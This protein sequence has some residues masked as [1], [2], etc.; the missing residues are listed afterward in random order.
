MSIQ[1]K[2]ASAAE[3]LSPGFPVP[4]FDATT[5][6]DQVCAC[7][8]EALTKAY[9]TDD[10]KKI[11][12][13]ITGGGA[14][15]AAMTSDQISATFFGGA[16]MMGSTRNGA[17]AALM[18]GAASVTPFHTAAERSAAADKASQEKWAERRKARENQR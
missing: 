3:I 5:T 2:I 8:R 12:D 6:Q 16:H 17:L 18:A 14:D 13:A 15:L 10:G 7:Q 11:I 1:T 9:A 4:T